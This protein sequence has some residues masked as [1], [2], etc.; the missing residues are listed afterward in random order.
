MTARNRF[1]RCN[2]TTCFE[3]LAARTARPRAHGTL[4]NRLA[5]AVDHFPPP[6]PRWEPRDMLRNVVG[7]YST[8]PLPESFGIIPPP[9]DDQ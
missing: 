5:P 9:S 4:K 1:A 2:E 3:S 8:P 6:S 7:P